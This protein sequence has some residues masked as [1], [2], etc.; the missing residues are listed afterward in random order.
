MSGMNVNMAIVLVRRPAIVVSLLLILLASGF[1][2]TASAATTLTTAPSADD[3]YADILPDE[4]NGVIAA[5]ERDI[6]RYVMDVVVDPA[7]G[8]VG[9]AMSITFVNRYDEPLDD[10]VLRLF[11]NASHYGRGGTAINQLTVDGAAA[12]TALSVGDTVLD[13]GLTPSLEPGAT[14]VI[15]LIFTTVVPVDSTGSY[16][17]LSRT[18]D[19]GAWALADWYP[20]L[21]GFEEGTGWRRD[22]AFDN[23]DPTFGDVALYD[24]TLR[25]PDMD[26]VSTGTVVT[27]MVEPSGMTE[28]RIVAGPV[29]D[30]TV[31]LGTDWRQVSRVVGGTTVTYAT[32]LDD[33]DA[34]RRVLDVVTRS[35]AQYNVRFGTYPYRK[36]ALVDVP[37]TSGTLGISWSGL[38]YLDG[39]SLAD[40]SADPL[41]DDFLLAHE[42]AHQWWGNLVGG[43]S[44]DH[45]FITEGL[46][47]YTM[48]MEV[49]WTQGRAAAVTMLRTY[50][51]SRYLALLRRSGDAVAD[52]PYP[53]APAGF[54]D[55]I[56]GKAALG[57][58]AIRLVIGDDAFLAAL[59]TFAGDA[60][61]VADG[62]RFQVAQ[63]SDLLDAFE[64]A[65]GQS[66]DALWDRWFDQA[67]TT[68]DDV[69]GLVA[70]YAAG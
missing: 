43:N 20:S 51:A 11:P 4:R 70:E 22:P 15:A 36:L 49:E 12:P 45:T 54:G 7:A 16:G 31:A 63:P 39:P 69:E 30:F 8:T 26:V 13:I 32:R 50:V 3:P 42:I 56:Y 33:D 52:Q 1:A 21:A 46:T 27:R 53:G 5:T 48:T 66:L 38:V 67:V 55:V 19:T 41:Y 6:S 47:N 40:A 65:S 37:L 18:S 9:G 24:V 64:T 17:I 60:S 2:G 25:M 62:F 28:T 68:P 59:R 34:V 29:R 58:L 57:F 23:V 35:L 61:F 10:I 44:N 14:T